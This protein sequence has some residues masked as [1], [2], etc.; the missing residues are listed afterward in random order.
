M[1]HS[2]ERVVLSL[3]RQHGAL[4]KS[5]I[6]RLTSLSAQTVSVI[7][8]ALE[9]EGLLIKGEPQRGRIGQP[10]VPMS[11][12]PDGAYF[13]GLKIGRGSAELVL[14]DFLGRVRDKAEK[15]WVYPTPEETRKFLISA[16]GRMRA[17]LSPDQGRRV[18][19]LGIAMPFELWNWAEMLGARRDL[20][21]QWRG[22][23]IRAQLQDELPFPVYLENDATSACGAELVFG[24]VGDLRD[25]V[26]FYIGAL[27]GGGV[28]L[29]G[30]LYSG[31]TNN[32][33]AL[34]SM[35]V[36]D[37]DGKPV[38]LIDIA[39]LTVLETRMRQSCRSVS[40]RWTDERAWQEAGEVAD[41]WIADAGKALAVAIVSSAA[42]I[43]FEAAIIEGWMPPAIRKRIVECAR[44]ALRDLDAEGLQLP[45][46]REGTVGSHARALGAAS[47]PLSE[48]FLVGSDTL[49]PGTADFFRVSGD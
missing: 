42:V 12:N 48:R 16:L 22:H 4:S 5:D 9:A 3:L 34:G 35:P 25:F 1:R 13:L 40:H 29:N 33:G 14:T 23:D 7:M 46:I 2:N 38:Q 28:V 19:G 30:R 11:L 18:A 6:A 41:I 43:D 44:A 26:Y 8:R 24:R 45:E 39:S 21:D 31:P 10:S 47:L 49:P 20:M 17:G 36:P 15:R 32:A 37:A 27:V